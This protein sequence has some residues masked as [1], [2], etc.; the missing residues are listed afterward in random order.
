[1]TYALMLS[2]FAFA[3]T[4]D[5]RGG[6]LEVT[7]PPP[8]PISCPLGQSKLPKVLA[9]TAAEPTPDVL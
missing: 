3:L 5:H 2:F 1:M 6:A 8:K 7:A 9:P 4:V